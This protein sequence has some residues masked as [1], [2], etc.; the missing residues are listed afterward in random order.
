MIGGRFG[1]RRRSDDGRAAPIDE[2]WLTRAAEALGAGEVRRLELA[3]VPSSFALLGLAG[4]GER[5]LLLAV[6]PRS[7]GDA[8]L[9]A[10]AAQAREEA[11][12]AEAVAAAPRFDLASRRLLGALGGPLRTLELGGADAVLPEL[13]APVVPAECL[14]APLA[15]PSERAL[16]E[17]A[18]AGLRGLAAKHGGATRA[19]RGGLELVILARVVAALRAEAERVVLEILAPDSASLVL[20]DGS[21][22][23]ALDRLEGGIRRRLAD[24]HVQGSEEGLR[25]RLT[26]AL[27]AA[28]G[29]RFAA[30]WPFAGPAQGVD[31]VGVDAEGAPLVGFV[32]ERLTLAE[33]GAALDAA[34]AAEPLLP[35]ALRD[36]GAP[37]Q[38]G[39]RPRLAFATRTLERAAE[40]ALARLALA[41]VRFRADGEVLRSEG[42]SGPLAA[43]PHPAERPASALEEAP[44]FEREREG[45]RRRRRRRGRGRGGPGGFGGSGGPGARPFDEEPAAAEPAESFDAFTL[46]SDAQADADE[47]APAARFEDA[48]E[49]EAGPSTLE[50]S[51]F[52]LGDEPGAAEERGAPRRRGRRRGRGRRG[53][54][55][56]GESASDED[57]PEPERVETREARAPSAAGEGETLDDELEAELELSPDAPE[58]EEV[59]APVPAYEDEEEG[60]PESELDRIRLE[61]ERRRRERGTTL[62]AAVPE[63]GGEVAA[64]GEEPSAPR[65]RAAILA[66]ADRD[67]IAAAVLLARDMRQLEGLWIYPQSELMTFFRGVATDLRESTPIYVVGFVPKPSRDVIQAASLYRGRLVWFDHHDWPPE[68]LLALR[69][70]LGTPLLRLTPGAGSSLPAVLPFCQRRSRFSDKFVDL[71]C[72][73]FSTH[74]F[75]R[76]GGLWWWRLGELAKK[77]GEHRAALELLIGGRPSDLAREAE[78][79]AVPPPPEELAWVAGRDF[80]LVRFGGLGV[81]VTEVP[82]ELDLPMT[83][84]LLRERYAVP[85]ALARRAGSETFVLVTDDAT[86]RRALD[87]GGMIEHLAEKFAWVEALPEDDHMARLRVR[88][89]EAHPERLDELIAE[90]GMS[91]ALLEG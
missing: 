63:P 79:A 30:R 6:S 62:G 91:R 17:R 78:R 85:L 1:R 29:L 70:A 67:S 75:Q 68:D 60:E 55:G 61:R 59:A 7:G 37:L 64:S 14:A 27:A 20:S 66:H 32:R 8:L 48:V 9:A 56:G 69:A 16:F 65:G 54:R 13:P 72:G 4:E 40:A 11:A 53:R 10:V 25:G 81:V 86:A 28:T 15:V 47:P 44:R 51:L 39:A 35:I 77:P 83:L 22:G 73:R 36:A 21:L 52:D 34:L 74:D 82:A 46:G 18:L 43:R 31:L 71:V 24:R 87:L 45:G 57:E 12:G 89:I 38:I 50:F 3:D 41:S 2:S 23:E 84:R 90:I 58:L 76:W 49:E 33:L 5:T 42:E 80:R 88:S 26:G 19:A